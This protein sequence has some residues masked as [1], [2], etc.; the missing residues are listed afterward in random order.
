[1]THCLDFFYD[2]RNT[3]DEYRDWEECLEEF[4][5]YFFKSQV[6]NFVR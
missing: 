5:R 3:D 1:M 6:K 2:Y 4:T